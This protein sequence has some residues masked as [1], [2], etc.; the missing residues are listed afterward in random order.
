MSNQSLVNAYLFD[1]CDHRMNYLG[2][3]EKTQQYFASSDLVVILLLCCSATGYLLL[4]FRSI[5]RLKGSK[6]KLQMADKVCLLTITSNIFRIGVLANARSI[7]FVDK[8]SLTDTYIARYVQVNVVL[9]FIYY[10]AGAVCSNIFLVGVVSSGAG[11]NLFPDLKIGEKVISPDKIFKLIRLVVLSITL[12]LCVGWCT[13]GVWSGLP[14][15]IM[16]RRGTF[17][18]SICSCAFISIPALYFFGNNVISQLMTNDGANKVS[19]HNEKSHNSTKADGASASVDG[20]FFLTRSK[21][22]QV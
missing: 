8:A 10:S 9:D 5:L 22:E 7:A 15:Y 21:W 14:Y 18:I 16:F 17:I 12:T 3:S 4:I 2:C 20:I 13:L 11:I 1:V 19:T 6:W